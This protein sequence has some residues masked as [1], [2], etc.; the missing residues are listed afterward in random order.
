MKV[1]LTDEQ[2][3]KILPFLRICPNIYTGQEHFR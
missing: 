3:Q 2:W 1:R